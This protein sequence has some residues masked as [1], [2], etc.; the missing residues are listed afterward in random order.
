MM[1]PGDYKIASDAIYKILSN[2]P[3][4]AAP[5]IPAPSV[6]VT[7]LWTAEL[8]FLTGSARHELTITQTDAKLS[9]THKGETLTGNL[10]GSVEGNRVLMHSSQRIQGTALSFQF[11]GTVTGDSMQ[12]TVDLAEYGK[13]EFTAR[14]A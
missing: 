8:K 11:A 12:G 5:E 13:A 14:R 9:G 7:G 3:K 2:P 6:N 1:Q 10:N 4:I